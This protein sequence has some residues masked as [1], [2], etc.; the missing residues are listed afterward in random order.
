MGYE[1][2]SVSTQRISE[3]RFTEH[4]DMVFDLDLI[5]LWSMDFCYIRHF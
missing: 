4:G 5:S 2:G 1:S 3:S